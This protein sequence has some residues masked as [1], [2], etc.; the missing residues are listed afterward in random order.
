MEDS[1]DVAKYVCLLRS[2]QWSLPTP[3]EKGVKLCMFV[4]IDLWLSTKNLQIDTMAKFIKTNTS[5]YTFI[6]FYIN[7][8]SKKN[9]SKRRQ[10]N[11][12]CCWIITLSN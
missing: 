11:L 1:T 12:T 6:Q 5:L 2:N 7:L 4:D 8:I 3:P 9:R 10:E